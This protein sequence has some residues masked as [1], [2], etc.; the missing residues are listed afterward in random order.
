ML[1]NS[2]YEDFIE[3]FYK[4][5]PIKKQLTKELM[6]LLSLEREAVYRRLRKEVVFSAN[7][8]VKIVAA[9]E[10]SLDEIACINSGQYSFQMRLLDYI[11]PSEGEAFFLQSVINEI[12]NLQSYP[13]A[14]CMDICNKLPRQLIVD[15]EYLNQ[16]S[17]FQWKYQ[18]NTSDEV[19]PFS[20]ISI[21]DKKKQITTDYSKA[22]KCVPVSSF[23]L[24]R[25]VFECLI[26]DIKYFHSIN[27]ITDEEK[28]FLK[29]DISALLD[30]LQDVAN[31]GY[32]PETHNKVN[33]FIS[34]L[35][36]D[37]NYNY[38]LSPEDNVCFIIVFE[39][40]EVFSFNSEM[41]NNFMAWM[42]QKKRTSVQIS[43]ADI[44]SRID[45]F[46][47]QRKLLENL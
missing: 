5:F 11:D 35:T 17:L 44:R 21:S 40:L 2:W 33:L 45:F 27:L 23:I 1:N 32:Y 9:W 47:R 3:I 36:V 28:E 4:K 13:T 8:I 30:Y 10:L 25:R 20:K 42:Q 41:V 15:Y 38:A 39:K 22:I 37:T 19:I 12:Y 16:Y 24:D 31:K 34:Q 29:K 18:N 43:E 14:E 7:E 46:A 26:N 6:E